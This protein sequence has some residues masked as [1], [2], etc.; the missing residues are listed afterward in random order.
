MTGARSL[1]NSRRCVINP[2]KVPAAGEG[3]NDG[4]DGVDKMPVQP[5]RRAGWSQICLESVKNRRAEAQDRGTTGACA[6]RPKRGGGVIGRRGYALCAVFTATTFSSG[7]G[8]CRF[9]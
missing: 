3:V 9:R 1:I 7:A 4:A 5:V 6:G 2:G 8:G